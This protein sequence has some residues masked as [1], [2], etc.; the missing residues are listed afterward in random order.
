MSMP[1]WQA[2]LD[3]L[4]AIAAHQA[5]D[6]EAGTEPL[7]GVGLGLEDQLDQSGGGG[8]DLA[9]LASQPGWRP[10]GVA[11]VRARHVLGH[12]GVPMTQRVV[13]MRGDADAMVEDL[14]RAVGDACLH[15]SRIRR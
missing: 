9:C 14:D 7:L 5:Q 4:S 13:D 8:T 3:T 10:V 12:R 6:A 2:G 15:H 11:A 1:R